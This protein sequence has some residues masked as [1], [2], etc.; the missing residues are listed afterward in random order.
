MTSEA[1]TTVNGDTTESHQNICSICKN[2]FTTRSPKLLPCLHT[3]CKACISPADDGVIRCALCKQEVRNL[4]LVIDNYFLLDSLTNGDNT[5]TSTTADAKCTSCEDNAV[6]SSYCQ[7]CAEWLCDTC[8]QA[9]H[10][11][12]VTKDHVIQPK[13]SAEAL[14]REST[15]SPASSRNKP[16]YCPVHKQE[17]LKLYCETCDKL[18]CRDCQLL[19]HKEHKYQ[20]VNEAAAKQ[21]GQMSAL[22]MKLEEKKKYIGTAQ[23]RISEK[24]KQINDLETKTS[25]EIRLFMLTLINEV[26]RRAKKLLEDLKATCAIKRRRLDVQAQEVKQLHKLIDH[27]TG[28]TNNALHTGSN[29]ALL[30]SKKVILSQLFSVLRLPCIRSPIF[31]LDVKFMFDMDSANKQIG[32][33]GVLMISDASGQGNDPQHVVQQLNN[34]VQHA[35]G[36]AFL[37]NQQR[38]PQ[39][40]APFSHPQQQQQQQKINLQQL[41]EQRRQSNSVVKNAFSQPYTMNS[42]KILHQNLLQRHHQQQQQL[43]QQQLQQQQQQQQQLQQHQQHSQGMKLEQSRVGGQLR[44]IAPKPLAPPSA[45]ISRAQL[46]LSTSTAHV[47]NN[48]GNPVISQVVSL[49]G[50]LTRL[51]PSTL[52][53]LSPSVREMQEAVFSTHTP[54]KASSVV[55]SASGDGNTTSGTPPKMHATV[56]FSGTQYKQDSAPKMKNEPSSPNER[57]SCSFEK[58]SQKSTTPSPASGCSGQLDMSSGFHTTTDSRPPSSTSSAEDRSSTTPESNA[59]FSAVKIKQERQSRDDPES[60]CMNYTARQNSQQEGLNNTPFESISELH[61]P[62]IALSFDNNRADHDKSLPDQDVHSECSENYELSPAPGCSSSEVYSRQGIPV[63]FNEDYCACCQNG[64]D[65]L[66]CDTCP[67]VFHLQC[68]IPSLTATPKETWICGLCQDLCKEIQGIS[69]NDEHGKRK[70]SS[71]LSE[72]HQ[73]ICERILLEL[74]CHP[75]SPPFHEPVDR[76]VPNYYKIVTNPMDL[77]TIKV[78]LEK[79]SPQHYEC[80]EDFISDC[81]L[82]LSNCFVFNTPDSA[83]CRAGKKVE[84][85]LNRLLE[86]CLP[87]YV[88]SS[89]DAHSRHHKRK[90]K[91]DIVHYK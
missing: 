62:N 45:T 53:Q 78:K 14:Q 41:A 63:E 1:S 55:S 32:K 91:I 79:T 10:R 7:N 9:H 16:L 38:P 76:S 22:M 15:T 25:Q 13:D 51:S 65:L 81:R 18:T 4:G 72:A 54:E 6:A 58:M 23:Q 83:I 80:V 66:C 71:G 5:T 74:F 67:K 61:I 30:Y 28:F 40:R 44:P 59:S 86:K 48:V 27:C 42:Q 49:G 37:G 31:G 89:P 57:P 19:E 17:P 2:G 77:S 26:N 39:Y 12:R 87:D 47:S 36:Q 70:A 88:V 46:Q 52:R 21:K 33:F 3:F 24:L 20:F 68:H 34:A 56:P 35:P 11:V 64:G 84:R 69:E 50:N 90:K 29:A 8:V 82:L 73:K 43:Q 60:S 75:A 85:F